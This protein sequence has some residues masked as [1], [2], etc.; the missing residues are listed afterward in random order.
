MYLKLILSIC[1]ILGF[2]LCGRSMAA[3]AERRRRT[4]EDLLRS[5]RALQIQI[6][7]SL[8]PLKSALLHTDFPLFKLVADKL[9]ELGSAGEAWNI[10][11]D[12]ERQRG[13]MADCLTGQDIDMLNRLFLHLGESG[14]EDQHNSIADCIASAENL[15]NDAA[16]RALQVGRLYTSIGFLAGLGAA[17]LII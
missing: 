6:C 3:S 8:E 13:R 7:S 2:T 9:T 16:E 11:R 15:L 10:V 5:L 14:L 12:S 4:L 17:I 1:I